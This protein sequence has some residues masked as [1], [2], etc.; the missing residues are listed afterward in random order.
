LAAPERGRMVIKAAS[1][2]AQNKGIDT[3]MVVA[4]CRAIL[5][6]LKVF[7]DEPGQMVPLLNAIGE[8]CLRYTPIVAIDLPEGLILDVSGCTHLW[9]GEKEYLKDI[10]NRLRTFGYDIRA[11]IADTIGAAW[12]VSRFGQVSPII[13]P[14]NHIAALL[15]LP[16]AALRLDAAILTRLDKLGLYQINSFIK[17]PRTALRRRF[18][19]ELLNRLDQA[20]GQGIEILE[21]IQPV[22]PYQERLP[23]LEPIRT[24]PG[25]EIALRRLLEVLCNRLSK[26]GKGLRKGIFKGYRI[27]GHL[28][29]IEI[30]TNKASN[31]IEHLFSLFKLKIETITPALGIELFILEAPLV[32]E[33]PAEQESLWNISGS[34]DETAIAEL[35]DRIA[36]KVG[37]ETIHRYLP[38]E[39]YWPERSIKIASSLQEKP[40][41]DWRVDQRRP[42]NLL[43][44]PEE[45]EVS[46]PLPDYPPLLFRYKGILHQIKKADGPERIEQEWWLQQGLH[47]DYYQVE[48]EYGV[49]YWLFRSGHYNDEE[50]KWFIHGF[51][52]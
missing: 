46:V 34:G 38:A 52:A 4:D 45:I 32:E 15:Q 37:S 36:G 23:S 44:K 28:E 10:L 49:R 41:I 50:T 2:T 20:T 9:G 24:A 51:F 27:D 5:P 31:N 11:S 43:R 8:W 25:I 30:G 47:R 6:E 7:D 35:L 22:L 39:H 13:E 26:E 14:G 33:V 3:G 1:I 21:P 40:L 19:Q 42:V 12:A 17:M 18:G 16:A 29:Q 48:D